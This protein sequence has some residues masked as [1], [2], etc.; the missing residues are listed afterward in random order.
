M[1]TQYEEAV[2]QNIQTNLKDP[3]SVRY[4]EITN[5]EKGYATTVTGSILVHEKRLWGWT[6]KATINA[7]NSHGSYV[8]S[9]TYTFLFHGG[10]IVHTASPLAEDEMK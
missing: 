7:K 4:L 8:G 3:D 6:V 5:P 1:P 9:K 2:R 10:K